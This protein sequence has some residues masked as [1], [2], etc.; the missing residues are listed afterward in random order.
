MSKKVRKVYLNGDSKP[1][2]NIKNI[3]KNQKY[4]ILTFFP[5]ILIN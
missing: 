4:N 3:I 2:N 5:L 1:K